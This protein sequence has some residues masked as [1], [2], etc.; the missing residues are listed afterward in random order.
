M[1][2][3]VINADNTTGATNNVNTASDIA[4]LADYATNPLYNY[5]KGLRAIGIA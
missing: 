2:D 5:G 4:G 1:A 3:V